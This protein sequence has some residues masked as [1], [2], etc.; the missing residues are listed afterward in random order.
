MLEQAEAFQGNTDLARGFK[1]QHT[2]NYLA[3]SG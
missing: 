3:L 1:Y 2:E